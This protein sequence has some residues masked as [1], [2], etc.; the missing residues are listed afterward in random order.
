MRAGGPNAPAPLTLPTRASR[1]RSGR[2]A[3]RGSARARLSR[4]A[5]ARWPG[6]EDSAVPPAMLG[7]FLRGFDRILTRHSLA[8]ATY[9][10]HFGEGCVHA[11]VNFDLAS[12]PG[13]ATFRAAMID[14]GDLVAS[15]GGSLSGEHGDGLARS[16]LL[17]MMFRPELIDAFRDFKTNFRSRLDDESGRDR[18]S[19]SARLA[20]EARRELS[21]ARSRDAFRLQRRRRTGRRGAQMRRN[22]QMPQDRCGHDVPVVHGD[23]RGNSFDPRPRAD[24][25]RG[26]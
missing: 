16:E 22:R 4:A 26:A 24:P 25:V 5:R 14:L 1:P 6:A 20:S 11:R 15:L 23:A 10:G 12:A 18:R 17:P 13:I 7:A 8:V 19:A 21:T 3:S 9:Y 2:F